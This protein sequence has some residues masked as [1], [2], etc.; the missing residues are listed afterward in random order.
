MRPWGSRIIVDGKPAFVA[1]CTRR[2]RRPTARDMEAIRQFVRDVR[3]DCHLT[4]FTV[5]SSR[6][7][8]ELGEAGA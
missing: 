5:D 4:R 3:Q 1:T 2:G 8:D 6:E 7:I